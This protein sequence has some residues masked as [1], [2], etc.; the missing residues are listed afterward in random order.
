MHGV[1]QIL[2]DAEQ[3]RSFRNVSE[4][5]KYRRRVNVLPVLIQGDREVC[6]DLVPVV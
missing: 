2:F 3:I 1:F 5:R 4:R 6:W